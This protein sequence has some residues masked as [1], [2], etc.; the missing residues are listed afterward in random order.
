MI[1]ADHIV[2]AFSRQW[3]GYDF[4]AESNGSVTQL[5]NLIEEAEP[6]HWYEIDNTL[7]QEGSIVYTFMCEETGDDF[8]VTIPPTDAEAVEDD[9]IDGPDYGRDCYPSMATSAQ[10]RVAE[11]MIKLG[12]MVS[13]FYEYM[14]D[15]LLLWMVSRPKKTMR[16]ERAFSHAYIL[17]D[18]TMKRPKL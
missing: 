15:C 4:T 12:W 16:R 2:T 14:D 10:R 7:D 5:S 9:E 11:P 17:P 3:P 1:E 13:H 18:G 8:T 6:T